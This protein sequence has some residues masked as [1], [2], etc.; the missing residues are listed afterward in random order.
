M[1]GAIIPSR[2]KNWTNARYRDLVGREGQLV[3]EVQNRLHAKIDILF[4]CEDSRARARKS[5]SFRVF[6]NGDLL[7]TAGEFCRVFAARNSYYLERLGHC[8]INMQQINEIGNFGVETHGHGRLVY[9]LPG[10]VA[11]HRNA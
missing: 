4:C 6:Q 10:A 3:N 9:H 8:G 1:Q 2:G 5:A 7:C 11:N